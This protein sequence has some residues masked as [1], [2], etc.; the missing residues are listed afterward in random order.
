MTRNL[1]RVLAILW[2]TAICVAPLAGADAPADHH[3]ARKIVKRVLPAYPE[4]ARQLHIKGAVKLLVTVE[5]NGTVKSA[6][7]LGGNPEFVI[8]AMDVIRKWKFEPA[9][10]QTME[11]VEIRFE[12]TE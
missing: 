3:A 5:P 11:T 1:A 9:A 6:K 2:L 4:L 8:A 7:A 10:Q 12:P